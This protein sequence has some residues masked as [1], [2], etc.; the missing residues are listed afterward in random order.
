[1]CTFNFWTDSYFKA[2][3][4]RARTFLY[5]HRWSKKRK[6]K[7]KIEASYPHYTTV[8]V[9][10]FQLGRVPHGKRISECLVRVMTCVAFLF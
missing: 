5:K 9:E 2:R 6:H 3:P 8:V 1:M 4:L 7:L 10:S